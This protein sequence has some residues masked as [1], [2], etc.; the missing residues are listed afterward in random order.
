MLTT[1]PPS[2]RF[3]FSRNPYY[4]RVDLE[5]RQLPYIDKVVFQMVDSGIIPAKTG[6]G[7]AD[8]QARELQ[9]DNYTFLK[10]GED[11]GN[12]EVRLWDSA[13]GS[14]FALYPNL[15]VN[16]PQWRAPLRDVRFRRAL[17]LEIGRAHV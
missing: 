9:F 2:E 1:K 8:L 17:S 6:A 5:G 12:Y 10:E 7:E 3:V 11:R 4:H 15:N 14:Q 16:D 13:T